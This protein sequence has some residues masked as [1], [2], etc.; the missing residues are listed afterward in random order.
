M[1]AAVMVL[2]AWGG[3][4]VAQQAPGSAED[5]SAQGANAI[6]AGVRLNPEQLAATLRAERGAKPLILQ[7]GSRVLFEQAHIPGAEYAGPAGQAEGLAGLRKR[8]EP[9]PRT[10]A[11]VIYCG[12]CPWDRCPNIEPAYK[13]LSGMGFTNV[14]VLYIAQNFGADW[15]DRGYPVEKG[16]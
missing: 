12:C 15:V 9:L 7:V 6:P 1:L 5:G 11:M 3:L 16:Q 14:K 8:V 13:L 4:G 10:S 2:A